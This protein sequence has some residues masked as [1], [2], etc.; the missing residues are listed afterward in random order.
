M[1]VSNDCG[2]LTGDLS[3]S[4]AKTAHTQA[5]S[6]TAKSDKTRKGIFLTAICK[7]GANW[8]ERDLAAAL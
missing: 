1:A 5:E 8:R 2:G 3:G 6:A 4:A 7:A